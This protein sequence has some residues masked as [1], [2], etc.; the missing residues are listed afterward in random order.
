MAYALLARSLAAD[1]H[2]SESASS[3]TRASALLPKVESV[4]LRLSIVTTLARVKAGQGKLAQ[5]RLDLRAALNEAYKLRSVPRQ[6]E[7]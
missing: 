2:A 1:G 6:L 4:A 7:I 5:A 3:A